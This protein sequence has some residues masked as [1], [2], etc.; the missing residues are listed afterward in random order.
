MRFPCQAHG[1][2]IGLTPRQ[3]LDHGQ[4]K[5]SGFGTKKACHLAEVTRLFK[6]VLGLVR[7]FSD[8]RFNGIRRRD[9]AAFDARILLGISE[10]Y[11]C[12]DAQYEEGSGQVPCGLYQEVS[13][14]LYT[15]HLAG[16]LE[17]CCQAT[18]FGILNQNNCA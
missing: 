5:M 8:R 15:T 6:I 12:H 3:T 11:A 18:S 13:R 1:L 2:S 17:A 7:L 9:A 14:L 10:E 16:A 4:A